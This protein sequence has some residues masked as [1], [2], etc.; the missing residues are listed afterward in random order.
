MNQQFHF[1]D[2]VNELRVTI[3][4][5]DSNGIE[6]IP[7]FGDRLNPESQVDSSTENNNNNKTVKS[8]ENHKDDANEDWCAVCMDGGELICCDNCPK[9]F[10]INCHIPVLDG[11]SEYVEFF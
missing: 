4:K 2:S 1:Q 10:H 6:V 7:E 11:V 3:A 5:L 9:V 8:S